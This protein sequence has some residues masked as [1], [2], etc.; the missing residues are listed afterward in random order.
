V[1][2]TVLKERHEDGVGEVTTSGPFGCGVVVFA[3]PTPGNRSQIRV[4]V[5]GE[6]DFLSAPELDCRLRRQLDALPTGASLLIDLSRVTHFSAAG[7]LV[8]QQIAA[9]GKERSVAVHLGPV[10]PQVFRVLGICEVRLD[11]PSQP[12]GG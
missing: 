1:I 6:I 7:V 9:I 10:S 3:V 4:I 8:L 12:P 11:A 2:T 5:A